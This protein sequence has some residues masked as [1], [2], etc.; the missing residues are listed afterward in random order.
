MTMDFQSLTSNSW[1]IQT[2][3]GERFVV[4]GKLSVDPET[5]I[6]TI[7]DSDDII[8][9]AAIDNLLYVTEESADDED[10]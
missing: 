6:V 9:V 8:F 3:T 4:T 5:R 2:L 10:N 7:A 1:I